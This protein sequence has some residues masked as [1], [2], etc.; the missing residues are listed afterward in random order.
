MA[1]RRLL[2]AMVAWL[3]ASSRVPC[4]WLGVLDAFWLLSRGRELDDGESPLNFTDPFSPNPK[5]G[6]TQSHR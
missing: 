6:Q 3:R 2:V 5:T 4:G 1:R